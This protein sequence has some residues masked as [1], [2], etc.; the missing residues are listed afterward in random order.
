[1]KALNNNLWNSV[2]VDLSGLDRPPVSPIDRTK[3][4]RK[5]FGV[6]FCWFIPDIEC[7]LIWILGQ[8]PAD[9]P[10]TCALYA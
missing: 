7:P 3:M 9:I 1:M 6:G 5:D 2:V 10:D 4:E 8:C